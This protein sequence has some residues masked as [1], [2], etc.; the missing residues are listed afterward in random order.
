[1][2]LKGH[3]PEGSHSWELHPNS[4]HEPIA[5]AAYNSL[6]NLLSVQRGLGSAK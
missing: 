4:P 1:M 6:S 3:D 2:G 5:A